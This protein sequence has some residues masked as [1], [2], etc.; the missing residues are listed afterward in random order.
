M[1]DV[2]KVLIY[3]TNINDRDAAWKARRE[4]FTGAYPV[5]TLLEISKLVRPELCVEI[6]AI[7]IL[8]ASGNPPKR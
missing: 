6:E 5:S 1:D 4:F 7:G 3:L 2:V 8:G